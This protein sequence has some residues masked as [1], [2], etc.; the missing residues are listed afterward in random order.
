M[1]NAMMHREPPPDHITALVIILLTTVNSLNVSKQTVMCST[2]VFLYVT[3]K[4]GGGRLPVY[5]ATKSW[6]I[7]KL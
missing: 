5:S 7:L 6:K 4:V 2:I 1:P 3:V